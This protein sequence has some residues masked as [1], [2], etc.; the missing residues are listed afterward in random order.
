M[1]LNIELDV[2]ILT[3]HTLV[4]IVGPPL[5]LSL[6]LIWHILHIS[7]LPFA[8]YALPSQRRHW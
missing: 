5:L 3:R 1:V 7:P 6:H 8:A 4:S 2:K